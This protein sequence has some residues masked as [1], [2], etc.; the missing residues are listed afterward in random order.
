MQQLRLI[1]LPFGWIYAL[2]VEGIKLCYR[3]GW[4]KRKRFEVATVVIGNLSTGG[5]GKTPHV[6][7]ILKHIAPFHNTTVL[8]RG[9][10]RKSK[11]VYWV[12]AKKDDALQ[13]GDEP[14]QMARKFEEVAVVLAEKRA[15]AIPLILSRLPQTQLLLLDDAMQHWPVRADSYI[16][17]TSYQ[18]PFFRDYPL[19]A[20]NLREFRCNYKRADILMVS[21]CPADLKESERQ[22][23]LQKL[24]PQKHQKVFFSYFKYGELYQ[25]Q[26]S[27]Q[28]ISWEELSE[29]SV[30][31]LTGI[32]NPKLLEERLHSKAAKF[33]S[34][35]YRDHY[36]YQ[37]TDW[38]NIQ[39]KYLKFKEKEEK[40]IFLTT[41]K[42]IVRLAPLLDKDT[43]I[44]IAPVEVEIAFGEAAAFQR[45]IIE[46]MY[47]K[48]GYPAS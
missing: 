28:R 15:E 38:N 27:Q 42:D 21:K 22:R 40:T 32:A 7:Y 19:P 5:T 46:V 36:N 8:S 12:D 45:A 2:I 9:Y 25:Y 48:K 17:L 41:E 3:L 11:G 47:K 10:G 4:L 43:E 1:L 37:Q 16:M 14:L 35:S 13:A 33:S 29:Y 18:Q 30:F 39:K 20:G 24:R 23:L 31:L 44:F 6:E 26:Q 34:I